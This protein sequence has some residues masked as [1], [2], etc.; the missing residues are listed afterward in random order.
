M[1]FMTTYS[2]RPEHRDAAVARFKETQGA[3]PPGVKLLGRWHD[4]SGNRGFTLSES[5]D[6]QALFKWVLNWSDL[7]DFEVKA[8]LDDAEF[9]KTLGA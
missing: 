1:L 4:I 8:V 2:F 3:P 6:A 7:I 9:A 5:S